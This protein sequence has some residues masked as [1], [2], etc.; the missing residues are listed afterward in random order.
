MKLRL[1]RL[2]G[3][4]RDKL[5]DETRELAD[6]ITDYLDILSDRDR[7]V[8]VVL[9]EFEEAKLRLHDERRTEI[10]DALADQVE[11]LIQQERYGRDCITSRLYQ[12]SASICLSCPKTWW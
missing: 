8:N 5:A 11:D 1:Q 9:A 10:S 3:M 2:T 6:K 12:K 4:E 7:L